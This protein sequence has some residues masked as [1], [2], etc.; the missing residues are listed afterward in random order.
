[1]AS[2]KSCNLAFYSRRFFSECSSMSAIAAVC[3]YS[4][5]L[6]SLSFLYFSFY[7]LSVCCPSLFCV[8]SSL[9]L[10]HLR[11]F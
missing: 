2:G 7:I 5:I 3:W 4:I 9:A 11:S 10:I 1:M 6:F 8:S